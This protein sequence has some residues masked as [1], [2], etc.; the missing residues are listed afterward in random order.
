MNIALVAK[1]ILHIADRI[2]AVGKNVL[3][4]D[5]SA[6]TPFINLPIPYVT[7]NV[8]PKIPSSVFDKCKSAPIA[9]NAT[10]IFLRQM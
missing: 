6:N 9:G 8:D 5:L 7:Y 1:Q 10:A 2:N 3:T 4:F